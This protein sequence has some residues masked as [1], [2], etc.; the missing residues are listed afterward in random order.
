[1]EVF[2]LIFFFI[3]GRIG[4]VLELYFFSRFSERRANPALF[5]VYTLLL[6]A[7][8]LWL[9]SPVF[10]L[11]FHA[12]ILLGIGHFFFK[13]AWP[14][15]AL[16][17]ILTVT[18]VFLSYG[19]TSPIIQL[20]VPLALSIDT[21]LL[22]INANLFN[23]VSLLLML[24]SYRIILKHFSM[25]HSGSQKYLTVFLLPVLLILLVEQYIINEVYGNV[26]EIRETRIVRPNVNNWQM[27]M[28]QFIAYLSLF[29]ILFVWKK[30]F[31][32]FSNKTRLALL[33]QEVHAQE[34]YLRETR[35][36]YRLTQSFRHDI[37]NHLLILEGLIEKGEIKRAQEYIGKMEDIS[38]SLS[39]PCHT[40]NVV[41]DTLLSEK[42]SVAQQN[43]IEVE[44]TVKIPSPCSVEDLDLCIVFANAVDNAVKACCKI[45]GKQRYIR[46]AGR[47]KGGFFMIEVQNSCS[48]DGSYQKGEGIGLSNIKAVTEKYHGAMTVEKERGYFR[49]DVLFVI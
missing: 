1:M 40:G 5:L 12:A 7:V 3:T 4:A 48:F 10:S 9:P 19:I 25:K 46:I 6:Y 35:S 21:I 29:C 16:A 28:I 22:V 36:R 23:L 43:A 41:V 14:D 47:Q 42:L 17:M 20:A 8:E 30:L 24:I 44:C 13:C 39:F 27:L 26:V 33:E 34:E 32:D 31:E 49:L 38:V 11:I 2:Q 45:E 18:V 15:M 37:K